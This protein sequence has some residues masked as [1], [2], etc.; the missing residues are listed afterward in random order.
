VV[1]F[2]DFVSKRVVQRDIVN[3]SVTPLR[4]YSVPGQLRFIALQFRFY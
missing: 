4:G 3:I 2:F 1:I